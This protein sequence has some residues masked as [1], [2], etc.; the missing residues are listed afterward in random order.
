IL[1]SLIILIIF[2]FLIISYYWDSWNSVRQI[3]KYYARRALEFIQKYPEINL[4]DPV[5]GAIDAKVTIF[6]YDDFLCAP[7]QN[8]QLDLTEIQKFYGNKIKIVFKGI[9]LISNP[10]SKNAMLAAYCAAEQGMFWE[11]KDLLYQNPALLNLEKYREYANQIGLDLT[12]FN[13]CYETQKYYPIIQQN[14]ADAISIQIGSIPTL[15]VNKQKIEG[16]FNFEML[17]N[18]IDQ[19]L[20]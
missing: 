20:K 11:Y 12:I 10:E 17:K 13:Q 18:I 15:Y 14:L 1:F 9:S 8:V 5:K 7:C 16:Y 19:E 6:E 4:Y 2:A 3:E